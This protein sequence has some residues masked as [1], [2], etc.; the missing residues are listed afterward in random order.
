M[1]PASGQ[2]TTRSRRAARRRKP[3][4][5][6][7]RA[8]RNARAQQSAYVSQGRSV[9]RAA[10]QQQARQTQRQTA[11]ARPLA[12]RPVRPRPVGRTPAQA[13]RSLGFNA[14][15]G[16][17]RPAQRAAAQKARRAVQRAPA[18]P[19]PHVPVLQNPTRA[20]AQAAHDLIANA[21]NRQVTGRTQ[22]ERVRSRNQIMRDVQTDPR[23]KALRDASS[24]YARALERRNAIV[25]A[26]GARPQQQDVA[27]SLRRIAGQADRIQG[28]K[29]LSAR[30]VQPSF[31]GGRAEN[32][33]ALRGAAE[34]FGSTLSPRSQNIRAGRAL[35]RAQRARDTYTALA[36]P[37]ARH[38][39]VG[40]ASINITPAALAASR[41]LAGA[42]ARTS[43]GTGDIG[44]RTFAR[45]VGRDVGRIATGP[46]VGGYELG[47]GAVDVAVGN[48]T[49]DPAQAGRG[50]QRL[51][52]L[53]SGVAQ[54]VGHTIAHPQQ[55]FREDPLLTALSVFGAEAA[56]G[57]IAGGAARA[58]GGTAE[59]AGLRGSLARIGSLERPPVAYSADSARAGI[60]RRPR[61]PNTIHALI[62][63]A[64]DARREP[65]RRPNG[66]VVTTTINGRELP[67]LKPRGRGWGSMGEIARMG[68][69]QGNFLAGR[70]QA[71]EYGVRDRAGEEFHIGRVRG[72]FKG[73]RGTHARDAVAMVAEGTITSERHFKTDLRA[74]RDMVAGELERDRQAPK[75]GK[76]FHS[77]AQ[78][79]DAEAQVG[80]IDRMLSDPRVEAQIPKIVAAGT[81]IGRRLVAHERT[82]QRMGAMDVDR[83]DRA[84]LI[85]PAVL[86]LGAKHFTAE[87]TAAL[88]RA[89]VDV[90]DEALAHGSLRKSNGQFISNRDIESELVRKGRDPNT[91]A[92]LPPGAIGRSAF[93]R[94][95]NLSRP[96]V[97]AAGHTRTGEQ[98]RR[99]LTTATA[100]N[101]R[102]QG[103]KLAVTTQKIRGVDQAVSE[104]GLLHPEGRYFTAKEADEYAKRLKADTEEELIPVR[105][106]P[107][108]ATAR[109]DDLARGQQSPTAMENLSQSLFNDRL[110]VDTR[111]GAKNVVL[112]P[113]SIVTQL[114]K[115]AQSTGEIQK[116][117]QWINKPFRAAVLPQFRWLTGNF[118]EPYILRLGAVG[119]GVNVAGLAT[120]LRAASRI[121]KT[122]LRSSDPKVQAAAREMEAQLGMGQFVG[123]RGASVRRT[124]EELPGHEAW[125][126]V[127]A[128][129][130]A[131]HQA[132]QM[133]RILLHGAMMPANAFFGVNRIIE[134]VANRAAFGHIARKDIRSLQGSWTQS[135]V[136]GQRAAE[137]AAR[138]LVNTPDQRLFAD[139]MHELLGKY[140]GY[141]PTA[142]A[143]FQTILPFVPWFLNS[144]RFVFWTLPAHHPIKNAV[145]QQT[146]TQ[147]QQDWQ[148]IHKDTPPGNLK[149]AIPN[150]KG[151][152]IDLARYT[153]FGAFTE[154]AG[155]GGY[156]SF[157][158]Q[159]LPQTAGAQAALEGKDPFGRDLRV[160]PGETPNKEAIALNSLAE[161]LVPYLAT[162]RRLREGGGTG[163]S[164]ST[165]LNPKVK[166]GTKHASALA[167]T[168]SP[169]NPTY[170]RAPTGGRGPGAR[171]DPADL[172]DIQQSVRDSRQQLSPEDLDEIRR[173]VRGG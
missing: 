73:I 64:N 151:G 21:I 107:A 36:P 84:R 42:V 56:V 135:V 141:G 87:E 19:M 94:R 126:P 158:G 61:S 28:V 115:H 29:P 149:F 54:S 23:L 113:A 22:A 159:V 102:E 30:P 169:F 165:A 89:G 114:A 72:E 127:I 52:R 116:L 144:A 85:H 96:I 128:K 119:S 139:Q 117:F 118:V 156:G 101:V 83:A 76:V 33:R 86:H 58:L 155:G 63:D 167:R 14:G 51:G 145:L 66:Q 62:Q 38:I 111:S 138:G 97:G 59:A 88:K 137:Q 49:Q 26:H 82:A 57:R 8:V 146:A 160:A 134:N 20:Q 108:K 35:N 93:H 164:N 74:Y 171:V 90:S 13:R 71:A 3:E 1:P 121:V 168:F 161:A 120:D 105:A 48:A 75:D 6:A 67:V 130:P 132:L 166:P 9:Q 173:Q 95:F 100:K 47:R 60:K 11:R 24:H 44:P 172:H 106:V 43:L 148:D 27:A 7:A 91:V 17:L 32:L 162:T 68:R 103:V 92:Y 99:G 133:S 12:S 45:N 10:G 123:G 16:D 157:T 129:V 147:V 79:R 25:I 2:T 31:T 55:S 143:L 15:Q 41:A 80:R 153:P 140:T 50:L 152:W 150:G 109:M 18:R 125:G 78:R 122:G 69:Q 65:L 70:Q 5:Q 142:R 131:I 124:I 104:H 163:Y 136:V 154:A 77:R 39:G 53:G 40:P 34:A 37:K 46:F 4:P 170:L 112:M 98:F 110:D 81:E